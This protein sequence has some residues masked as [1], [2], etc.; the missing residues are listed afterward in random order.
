MEA[1]Y[2]SDKSVET[3]HTTR[4]H[5]PEEEPLPSHVGHNREE[6]IKVFLF[7]VYEHVE[8]DMR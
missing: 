7:V 2:S 6:C 4:H 1:A 8:Q 3:Y 5:I